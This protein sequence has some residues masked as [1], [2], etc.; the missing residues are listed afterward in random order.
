MGQPN[1]V[2]GSAPKISRSWMLAVFAAA[3]ACLAASQAAAGKGRLSVL[4]CGEKAKLCVYDKSDVGLLVEKR[5]LTL[6]TGDYT[7]SVSCGTNGGCKVK[8]VKPGAICTS[9][10]HETVVAAAKTLDEAAYRLTKGE[11]GASFDKVSN[12]RAH[13]DTEANRQCSNKPLLRFSLLNCLGRDAQVC[14]YDR[15]KLRYH[16][17]SHSGYSADANC[18]NPDTCTVTVGGSGPCASDQ[19]KGGTVSTLTAAGSYWMQMRKTMSSN[20]PSF[21]KASDTLDYFT[22]S[23]ACPAK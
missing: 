10:N 5:S 21:V 23:R 9:T 8:A 13:F 7:T 15:S 14:V 19:P 20:V 18:G 22:R 11:S 4:N 3:T 17:F 12:D 16:V 2:A 6:G 1:I